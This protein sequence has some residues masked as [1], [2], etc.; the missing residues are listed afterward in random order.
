MENRLF[1]IFETTNVTKLTKVILKGSCVY[2]LM[3]CC[4]SFPALFSDNFE[5]KYLS[6]YIQLTDQIS[7]SGWYHEILPPNILQYT[8]NFGNFYEKW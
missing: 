3:E 8:M 4:K 6:G 2:A 5:E 1:D 7:L